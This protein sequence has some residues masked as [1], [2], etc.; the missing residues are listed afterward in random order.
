MSQKYDRE[1]LYQEIW[2]DPVTEV[3][4]RY[5]MSDVNLRKICKKLDIPLPP[6]GY[7]SKLRAGKK[8]S[9][10]SLPKLKTPPNEDKPKSGEPRVLHIEDSAL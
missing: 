1:K 2:T 8:V 5:Q 10:P 6:A 3:A 9:K 7:W 4:K